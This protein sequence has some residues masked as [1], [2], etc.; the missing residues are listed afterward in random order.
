MIE[1]KPTEMEL[2]V[3]LEGLNALL[4]DG[5]PD[6]GH[7]GLPFRFG[8][9]SAVDD[10][11][12][13]NAAA[14]ELVGYLRGGNESLENYALPKLV[15]KTLFV[16]FAWRVVHSVC[17]LAR[18]PLIYGFLQY[19]I[20]HSPLPHLVLPFCSAYLC[21]LLST[22]FPIVPNLDGLVMTQ[23]RSGLASFLVLG[24]SLR[25]QPRQRFD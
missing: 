13:G 8:E 14:A 21:A 4:D 1:M 11:N 12:G 15:R 25:Q 22:I 6:S 18:P 2:P 7:G 23:R 10:P 5:V 9:E 20:S 24:F 3:S 17:V 19:V 16:A